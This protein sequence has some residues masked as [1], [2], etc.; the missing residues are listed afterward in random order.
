MET[1]HRFMPPVVGGPDKLFDGVAQ[2][3][4]AG[5]LYV[6]ERTGLPQRSTMFWMPDQPLQ[7]DCE[8]KRLRYRYPTSDN[9]RTLTFVGFQEP[10]GEI[11]AGTLLRVSLAH[12]WRPTERSQEELRCFVQLSGWFLEREVGSQ[13]PLPRIQ[14]PALPAQ[15]VY[16]ETSATPA[17]LQQRALEVLKQTFGFSHFLPTQAE[18]ID[19]ILKHQDT[20]I[21]MPT[22]G[23]K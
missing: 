16:A 9:G 15:S 3:T 11:A 6:A 8:G 21:V 12:W 2:A 10:L 22:G 18:A 13:K 5:G 17:S 20:L 19:R 23:G 1:I 7:L 4:A 14:A